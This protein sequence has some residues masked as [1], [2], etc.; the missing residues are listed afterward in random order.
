VKDRP[1]GVSERELAQALADGWGIT[2]V[3]MVYAPVGAG[4]YHWVVDDARSTRWVNRGSPGWVVC[5]KP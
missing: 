4:S 1:E 2:P 3:T 5:R